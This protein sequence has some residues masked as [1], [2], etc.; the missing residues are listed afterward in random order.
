MAHASDHIYASGIGSFH[1]PEDAAR[2][3]GL[4]MRPSFSNFLAIYDIGGDKEKYK[5]V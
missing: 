1:H 2:L 3:F 4:Q 5:N